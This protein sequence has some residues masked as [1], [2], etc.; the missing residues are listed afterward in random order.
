MY[1]LGKQCINLVFS[2]KN[3]KLIGVGLEAPVTVRRNISKMSSLIQV[4]SLCQRF[5]ISHFP[6]L[7]LFFLISAG[8]ISKDSSEF[9][10]ITFALNNTSAFSNVTLKTFD[11]IEPADD[12]FKQGNILIRSDQ[13]L[14]IG[15]SAL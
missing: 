7:L 4:L 11:A 13:E 2:Y 12:L 10:G 3:D 1:L 6:V 15:T 5:L 14:T 8:V 9:Y